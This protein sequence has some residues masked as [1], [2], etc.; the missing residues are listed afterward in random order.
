MNRLIIIEW[1]IIFLAM[2]SIW[3]WLAGY[4]AIWYSGAQIVVV[5]TLIWVARNRWRRTRQA[6]QENDSRRNFPSK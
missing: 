2:L 1:V 3:P 4:R 6:L 5:L